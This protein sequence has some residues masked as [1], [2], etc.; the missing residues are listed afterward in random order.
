VQWPFSL[1]TS[2]QAPIQLAAE[3][4]VGVYE[5]PQ[6]LSVAYG[7]SDGSVL[8]IKAQFFQS[9][10]LGDTGIKKA[11]LERFVKMNHLEGVSCTYVLGPGEYNLYLVESPAVPIQER[12]QAVSW[13]VRDLVNFPIEE[14]VIDTFE[15]PFARARDNLNML[16]AVVMRKSQ[17][18]GIE[19]FVNESGLFLTHIDIPELVL[20]NIMNLDAHYQEGCAVIQMH[21]Q[22]GRLILLQNN[23]ICMIR[24][25]DLSLDDLVSPTGATALESLCLEIQ[26]SFDYVNSMFRKNINNTVVLA[27]T[28]V[29]ISMIQAAI[30]NTLGFEVNIFDFSEN[31]K[32]EKRLS[33]EERVECIFAIGALLKDQAL[34]NET[35]DKPLQG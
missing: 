23:S 21:A 8:T 25:F 3:G 35:T 22:G 11:A 29:D 26:R 6:S 17:M 2:T 1:T 16:Y 14:A 5:T 20:K 10:S 27:K 18:T 13:L 33:D 31:I 34:E 30:K 9:L 4:F 24:S 32:A 28:S 15:L 19:Q 7:V 12:S